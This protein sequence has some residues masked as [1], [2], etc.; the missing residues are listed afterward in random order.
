MAIVHLEG[1][2][3]NQE[4]FLQL[5]WQGLSK[6]EANFTVTLTVIRRHRLHDKECKEGQKVVGSL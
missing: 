3:K 6:F 1:Y 2:G 4:I 5:V